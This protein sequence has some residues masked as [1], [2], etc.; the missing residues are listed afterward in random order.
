MKNHL[1]SLGIGAA[2]IIAGLV[3]RL[4]ANDVEILIVRLGAVGVVLMVAGVVEMVISGFALA[5][6]ATRHKEY[7][8]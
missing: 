7:D 2:M 3:L 5:R 8:L 1:I 6:P 4:T